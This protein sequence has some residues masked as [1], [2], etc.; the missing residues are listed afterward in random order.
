MRKPPVDLQTLPKLMQSMENELRDE[1][2][3]NK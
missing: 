2:I 1:K 3:K